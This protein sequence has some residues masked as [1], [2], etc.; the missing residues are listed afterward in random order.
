[1]RRFRHDWEADGLKH[2]QAKSGVKYLEVGQGEGLTELSSL[3]GS[4]FLFLL[5]SF[6]L[7]DKIS[8]KII[9][10]KMHIYSWTW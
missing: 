2:I 10:K 1:M 5:F 9:N 6:L 7:G 8:L 4:F 3:F